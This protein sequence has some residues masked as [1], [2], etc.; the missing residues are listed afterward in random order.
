MNMILR[1]SLFAGAILTLSCAFAAAQDGVPAGAEKIA[2]GI[3]FP[4]GPVIDSLGVSPGKNEPKPIEAGKG[5]PR[6]ANA[7]F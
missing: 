7:C 1:R 2:E 6:D 5:R 3:R 4:E